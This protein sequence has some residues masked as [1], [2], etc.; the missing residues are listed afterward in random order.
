M[1]GKNQR[2]HQEGRGSRTA[3]H[4][5]HTPPRGPFFSLFS[6][7]Y[8]IS[9]QSHLSRPYEDISRVRGDHEDHYSTSAALPPLPGHE[10]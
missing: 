8:K 7:P 9:Q 1:R 2:P 10:T 5:V 4:A 3:A 6:R